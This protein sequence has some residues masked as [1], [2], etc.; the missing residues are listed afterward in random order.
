MDD[1]IKSVH[2]F[3]RAGDPESALV[4]C[5]RKIEARP[6]D[7]EAWF[8]SG[9]ASAQAHDIAA[10][11]SAMSEALRLA[12]RAKP[13]WNLAFANVLLDAGDAAK[14]EDHARSAA[15]APEI[16]AAAHNVL[17]LAL[18]KQGRVEEAL[19][20]F[21]VALQADPGHRFAAANLARLYEHDIRLEDAIESYRRALRI[22]DRDA[23]LW[24]DLGNALANAGLQ[25]EAATAYRE[26]LERSPTYHQV[27]S[28]LLIQ[29]HYDAAITP[30]Q[31]FEAHR[32]WDRRHAQG[33]ARMELAKATHRDRLRVGFLSP[34]FNDSPTATFLLPLVEHLDAARFELHFFD[35]SGLR[36][37]VTDRLARLAQGWHEAAQDSDT[38]LAERIRTAELDVLVDLAG[39][40]PGG[41]PLVLARK[42]A[43]V[44]ATWLDYFDTT[45]LPAVDYLIGDPI[46]TPPD[47]RQRFVER[48]ESI[49]PCRFCYAPPHYAPAVSA[50]PR[51]RT[52]FT[53][54]G[55][56]NRL[57]KLTPAVIDAW[58]KVLLAIDG[59][60]LVLKSRA[61]RDSRTRDRIAAAFRT[62]GLDP[63]RLELRAD[64]PHRQMLD[65]YSG[66]D[67]A[68]DPFPFNG[69]LTTC[70]AIWMGVPV[71]ALRGDS[72]ISR[73]SASL[74]CAANLEDWI[75][76]GVEALV[77][78]AA[79]RA[80]DVPGLAQLR[81]ELRTRVEASPLLDAGT[82]AERFGACLKRM[83]DGSRGNRR[84][85]GRD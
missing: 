25:A 76:E 22:D 61:F 32:D 34:R 56:F 70:E 13:S 53:T 81:S 72:L 36:D 31:L 9:L 30:S 37:A 49:E 26:S 17:G 27:H 43:P 69:G 64:S 75:V 4:A 65:E 63:R 52:G 10:A 18:R 2:G 3:L 44:I 85:Q 77:R 40:N 7:A 48:I 23:D 84:R 28:N 79:R 35:L 62:R 58:T 51:L 46:S 41:R 57:S 8:L 16:K 20:A 78:E 21:Q 33:L 15:A 67:I 38:A 45:G 42:P 66:I 19:E 6:D 1:W 29:L 14:A 80:A 5:R 47:G 60:R 55:S 73:Q 83:V 24:C 39:H 74:L 11:R 71:L 82:F 50:L 12:P 54:F 59:S 68:L